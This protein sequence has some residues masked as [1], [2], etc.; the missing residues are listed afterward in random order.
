MP[1]GVSHGAALPAGASAATGSKA[2]S[3]KLGM[4]VMVSNISYSETGHAGSIMIRVL[5]ADDG[6]HLVR[7][8][9]LH[10]GLAWQVGD[11]AHPA[12]P[13]FGAIL[14]RRD[15]PVR[16]VEGTGQDLDAWS[17]DAAEAQGCA[18]VAAEIALGDRRGFE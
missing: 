16:P 9:I 1:S 12:E 10:R 14:P 6:G 15:H 18:A 11:A 4:R 7:A 5:A 13:R 2:T 17:V 8:V 3:A